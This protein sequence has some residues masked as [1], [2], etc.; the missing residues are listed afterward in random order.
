MQTSQSQIKPAAMPPSHSNGSSNGKLAL[1]LLVAL[2]EI[3]PRQNGA[4]PMSPEALEFMADGL[5]DLPADALTR[6]AT[7]ARNA[8]RWFPTV[9]ELRD[10]AGC[11]TPGADDA[12]AAEAMAAWETTRIW[13]VLNRVHNVHTG[14]YSMPEPGAAKPGPL[15]PRSEHA[16]RL[17]GGIHRVVCS[18]DT[19]DEKW[20][21]RDFIEAYRLAPAVED[22]ARQLGAGEAQKLAAVVAEALTLTAARRKG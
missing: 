19:D 21:R 10:M 15:R 11:G 16:L 2:G 6:A 1:R 9:A 13:C 22:A 20:C 3:L 4:A 18:R 12:L 8:C 17:C 14:A 7:R 5:A